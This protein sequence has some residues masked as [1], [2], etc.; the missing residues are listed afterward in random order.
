L[1]V[2]VVAH[3][4]A[5]LWTVD[6]DTGRLD[7]LELE[8]LADTPRWT[9][10]GQRVAFQWRRSDAAELA[11]RR[12]DRMGSAEVLSLAD[13]QAGGPISPF[14]PSSWRYDGRQ[15]AM[16]VGSDIAVATIGAGRATLRFLTRTPYAEQS[17]EF[18]PDGQWLAYTSNESRRHEV[19]VRPYPGD[20]P[21]T[22]V[23]IDGGTCPAWGK[24]GRELYFLSPTDENGNGRM[25]MASF[26]AGSPPRIG[27]P[28]PLFGFGPDLHFASGTVRSHDVAPDGEHFY[29]VQSRPSVPLPPVTH[30]NLIQNWFEELKAK[31]PV[32]R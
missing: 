24:K 16:V 3:G 30:V 5:G 25:M 10:D 14:G 20:G 6:S 9:P 2:T 19:Y 17:P 32:T 11:W 26:E 27:A 1:A 18:S 29:V 7:S 13:T 28:R 31:V 8:E 12:A 21:S 4:E 22:R 23:S 15:L